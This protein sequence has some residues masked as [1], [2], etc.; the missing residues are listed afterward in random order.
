[1]YK[2][3]LVPELN[4]EETSDRDSVGLVIALTVTVMSIV[5][6]SPPAVPVTVIV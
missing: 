2:V 6:V 5:W 1:M 4:A 3:T